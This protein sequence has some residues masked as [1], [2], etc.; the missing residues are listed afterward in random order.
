MTTRILAFV[1][2]LAA[3]PTVTSAQHLAADSALIRA[4]ERSVSKKHFLRITSSSVVTGRIT[5]L[6]DSVV[7][8][9]GSRVPLHDIRQ[10]EYRTRSGGGAAAGALLGG[11]A[12]GTAM[13]LLAASLG[14]GSSGFA[15]AGIGIG[16]GAMIGAI[17][18]GFVFPARE[19]W[20]LLWNR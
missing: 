3:V 14:G 11:L 19:E 7:R 15:I 6:P 17:V 12:G 1:L 2:F 9:V 10:L 5:M 18:G 4:L 8:I 13:F 16:G 20:H